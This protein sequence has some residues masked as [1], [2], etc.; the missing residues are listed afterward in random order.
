M[1]VID[2]SNLAKTDRFVKVT[3]LNDIMNTKFMQFG[4][5]AHKLSIDEQMIPYYGRHSCKMY[6]RGK[7]ICFGF[8][9]WDLCSCNCGSSN[10]SFK[11]ST[12]SPC[13]E[14]RS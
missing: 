5:F 3:P 1:Y 2:N 13:K 9:Y 12:N 4:V 8:K 7:P 10:Q 14:I 6:I 11:S